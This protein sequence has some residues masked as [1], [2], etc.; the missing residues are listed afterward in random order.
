[1]IKNII[2]DF[3]GVIY[4]I[5]HQLN[6]IAF[7]KLGITNFE[8]LY[9]H[10][11]QD[12]LFEDFEKGILENGEFR[13]ALSKYFSHH[14][15]DKDLDKAWCSLLIGVQKE[16]LDLLMD[17]TQN[18][19]LFLLSNTTMIHYEHFIKELNVDTDFRSLF[20]GVYFSHEIGMRKPDPEFYLKVMR[21]HQLK[22]EECLFI[23]D[24]D[25]N[26]KAAQRLGMQTHYLQNDSVLDLFE[27]AKWK[28]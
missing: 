10:Q 23:D 5:D 15:D 18:Y 2:F 4:D 11:V 12:H 26:I 22:A 25:V 19:K 24:L 21:D 7:E 27:N 9:S 8:S 17:L 14:V 6:K 1:M 13:K 20:D 3:G 16:K 28:V